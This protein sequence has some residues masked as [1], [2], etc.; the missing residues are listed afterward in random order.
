MLQ[1]IRDGIKG[2]IAYVIIGLIALPFI[3][4]GG[5]EY[6]GGGQDEAV[7]ARVDGEEITRDQVERMVQ[8]QRAQL[9]EMFGGEIP[10]DRFD[11]RALRRESLEQ[12]IDETLLFA[13]VEGQGLR[14]SDQEVAREIRSQ[15]IFHEGG[16]FSQARYRTLLERNR[17]SPEAYEDRVRRDLKVRQIEQAVFA[18]AATTPSEMQRLVRLQDERRS[19]AYLEIDADRFKD[20]I[21]IDDEAVAE[22]YEANTQDYMAPEAVRVRYV[23]LTPLDLRDEAEL[24]DEAVRERYEA[25]YGDEED[26]PGL[27]AVREELEA[28]LIREQMGT[29][30]AQ[31]ADRLGNVAFEEPASLEPVAEQFGL[32]VRTSDWIERGGASEGIGQHAEVVEAA[33]SED[34]LEQ[35]FNSDLLEPE[36]DRYLVLRRHEHREAEPRPLEAVAEQ[37]RGELRAARAADKALEQAEALA[38]ELRAGATIPELAEEHG[39]EAFEADGVR[40]EDRGHPEAVLQ[41]AFGLAETGDVEAVGLEDGAAALVEL[42]GIQRGDLERLSESEREQM[43]QQLRRMAGNAEVQALVRALRAE[44]K[45]EVAEERL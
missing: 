43:R 29:E 41:R 17:M 21:T 36:A 10:D 11:G 18:S 1:A 14:V 9:R 27:E 35:G 5:Y 8:R 22:H 31:R 20:D 19:F 24:D 15:E 37:I 26:A 13:F 2:W 28:E 4:M 38:E 44:A 25:R 6:F 42:S 40:R 7:V 16:E 33:F 23:E 3:F 30:L 34:V 39:L 45:I 32:E 12:L